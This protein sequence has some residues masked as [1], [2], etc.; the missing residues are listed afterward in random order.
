[1][2][3]TASW[4]KARP[5]SVTLSLDDWFGA[6]VSNCKARLSFTKTSS[7][8]LIFLGFLCVCNFKLEEIV[9]LIQSS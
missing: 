7:L 8:S 1:M 2:T 4:T 5:Y 3:E 9:T 6:V